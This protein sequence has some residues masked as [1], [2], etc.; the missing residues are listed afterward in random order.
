MLLP[1]SPEYGV[2]SMHQSPY[3]V[4]AMANL[5]ARAPKGEA[6]TTL[7]DTPSL[8]VLGT[9]KERERDPAEFP[10]MPA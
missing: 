2:I 9:G 5:E 4:Y 8:C 10:L 6:S 3:R 7:N 1:L